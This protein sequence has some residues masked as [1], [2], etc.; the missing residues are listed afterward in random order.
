MEAVWW[1]GATSASLEIFWLLIIRGNF[2]EERYR[3]EILQ[4]VAIPYLH[5]LRSNSILQDDNACPHRAGFIRDYSSIWEWRWWNGLPAVRTSTQLNTCG[6]SSVLPVTYTTVLADL[7]QMLV[8]N[9]MTSHSSVWGGAR[10]LWL[11]MVFNTYS[12][13]PCSSLLN[14]ND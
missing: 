12:S 14:L 4:T 8:K 10:S 6:I 5:N 11:C 1:C 13:C 3:G 7:Q 9:G 2:N